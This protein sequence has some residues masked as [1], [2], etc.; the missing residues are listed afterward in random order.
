MLIRSVFTRADDAQTV[1]NRRLFI[2]NQ[3][4]VYDCQ[5]SR[6]S[7]FVIV[8]HLPSPLVVSNVT[9]FQYIRICIY[10]YIY[11]P[12]IVRK[13]INCL[14]SIRVSFVI[15]TY[16]LADNVIFNINRCPLTS[17]IKPRSLNQRCP[18]LATELTE[19]SV[20]YLRYH[21]TATRLMRIYIYSIY[22]SF[23]LD[24]L[25]NQT[26]YVLYINRLKNV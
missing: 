3:S 14:G 6:N 11:N 7:P 25:S 2:G 4:P 17:E 1:I 23:P 20:L 21:A 5:S 10:I 22:T 19:L 24:V 15:V 12:S 13:S 16:L 26:L 9:D 8:T 18:F